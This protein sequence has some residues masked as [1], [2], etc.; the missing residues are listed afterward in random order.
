MGSGLGLFIPP[1]VS[2]LYMVGAS[3][4][5]TISFPLPAATR[6]IY[7]ANLAVL[8]TA[9]VFIV[10]FFQGVDVSTLNEPAWWEEYVQK[11]LATIFKSIS[12]IFADAFPLLV[13]IPL[14]ALGLNDMERPSSDEAGNKY[15]K[16]NYLA[17]EVAYGFERTWA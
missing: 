9:F 11:D 15:L 13:C 1:L 14:V 3:S 6:A 4:N 5:K 17:S 12:G 7:G 10:Q 2:L 8:L 16:D